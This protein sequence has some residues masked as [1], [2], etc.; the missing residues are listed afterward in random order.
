MTNIRLA[1]PAD[2]AELARMRYEF[3]SALGRASEAEGEFTERCAAWMRERLVDGSPWS[4]WVLE[5]EGA[6][7]GQLWL[8]LIEK[9]P[10]PVPELELH[11]YITNIYVR[12]AARGDGAGRMLLEAA[13]AYCRQHHVDSVILWPTDRS[14]TLYARHGFAVRDDI[15][16]AVL[17]PA[18]DLHGLA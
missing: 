16:E 1:V 17:D 6:V 2:A 7:C 10:N 9:V 11:G 14:R 15:M 18:R 5:A 13:L 12:P 3:R 4:C 8:Q